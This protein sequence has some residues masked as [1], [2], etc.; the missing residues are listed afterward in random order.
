M[1]KDQELAWVAG[2]LEGEGSFVFNGKYIRVSASMT[3]LDVLQKVQIILGGNLI[4][5]KAYEGWKQSWTWYINTNAAV[6]CMKKVL[7]FLCTRRTEQVV[8]ALSLWNQKQN[9]LK[10]KRDSL[11]ERN[12][13]VCEMRRLGLSNNEVAKKLDLT[14]RRASEIYYKYKQ[15]VIQV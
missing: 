4:K 5:N 9:A 13:A 1:T 14:N 15:M 12:K 7:P 6:E 10:A 3:D 2:I 11:D 8:K